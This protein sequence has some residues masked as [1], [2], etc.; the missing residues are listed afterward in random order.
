MYDSLVS[1]DEVILTDATSVDVI[2]QAAETAQ[3]VIE[4]MNPQLIRGFTSPGSET[5][6][7]LPSGKG[8]IFE[9]N[10]QLIPEDER[11]SVLEHQVVSG[12]TLRSILPCDMECRF[13]CYWRRIQGYN[14][15]GF[16]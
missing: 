9:R 4:E 15:R 8:A 16:K 14:P 11:F 10:Y 6:I 2:A 3:R 1:F 13:R 7:M 12:D 5:R